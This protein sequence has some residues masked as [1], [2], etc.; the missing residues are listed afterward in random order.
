MITNRTG[1]QWIGLARE[2]RRL[3]PGARPDL[4]RARPRQGAASVFLK[5]CG[6]NYGSPAAANASLKIFLIGL[7]HPLRRLP[8][9][10]VTLGGNIAA[11]YFGLR[12][13]L[14]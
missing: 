2:V 7:A 4:E 3:L 11:V 6:L 10:F 14:D 13:P 8:R 9:L 1:R 12:S 5:L